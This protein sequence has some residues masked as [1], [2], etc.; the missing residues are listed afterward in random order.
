MITLAALICAT[1]LGL[2]GWGLHRFAIYCGRRAAQAEAPYEF[3]TPAADRWLAVLLVVMVG[4]MMIALILCI[5]LLR[6]VG[7]LAP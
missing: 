7:G 1:I 6:M 3:F 2:W 4:A 5:I